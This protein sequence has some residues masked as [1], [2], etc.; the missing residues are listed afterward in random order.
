VHEGDDVTILGK[1]TKT[2]TPQEEKSSQFGRAE[3]HSQLEAVLQNRISEIQSKAEKKWASFSQ[4]IDRH[5]AGIGP[6]LG[7]LAGAASKHEKDFEHI[8]HDSHF[9]KEIE[10]QF[11]ISIEIAQIAWRNNSTRSWW[12]LCVINVR[13]W[14]L[15]HSIYW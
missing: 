10:E 8:M 13:V 7:A 1:D 14:V 15:S 9:D 4:F 6:K 11:N 12:T 5:M 3:H 2:S